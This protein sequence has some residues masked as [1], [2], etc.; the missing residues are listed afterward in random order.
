MKEIPLTQ[1]KVALVD[2]GDYERL[3]KHKWCAYHHRKT[4]YAVRRTPITGK[5]IP[6]HRDIMNAPDGVMVD[7]IN[8]DGLNNQRDNLRPCTNSQNLMNR[9]LNSRNT[10]GYKGVRTNGKKW[11]AQ[12]TYKRKIIYLG[13]FDTPELAARAYDDAAKKYAGEFARTNF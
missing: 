13:T 9:G 11:S 12:I 3:M 4:W 8:G 7:H 10:T 6:M 5:N 1:G 2:D